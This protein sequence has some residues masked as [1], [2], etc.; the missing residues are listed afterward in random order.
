VA[1]RRA[2]ESHLALP[3]DEGDDHLEIGL[4]DLDAG[5]LDEAARRFET[6]TELHGAAA[7]RGAD[8]R[9][10]LS[11]SY[12]RLGDVC[13]LR[14]DLAAARC[15]DEQA[16]ASGPPTAS[17]RRI[18]PRRHAPRGRRCRKLQSALY[19]KGPSGSLAASL[20]KSAA[21][22]PGTH[23][24]ERATFVASIAAP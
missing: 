4:C 12:A 9:R 24:A 21:A 22:E 10:S 6:A 15:D 20:C 18:C 17:A 5:R 3:P 19:A 7:Q 1:A 14:G 2:F 13:E 16:V 11:S 8:R 23:A